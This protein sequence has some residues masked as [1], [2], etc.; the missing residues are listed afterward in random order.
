FHIKLEGGPLELLL[1]LNIS[2]HG[3]RRGAPSTPPCDAAMQGVSDCYGSEK[4][5]R[6]QDLRPGPSRASR[7][8][9]NFPTSSTWTSSAS[10]DALSED[11][12][13]IPVRCSPCTQPADEDE[14]QIR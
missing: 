5:D 11:T 10:T 1:P 8:G 14:T 4:Q 7:Y 9:N 2:L 6:L 13:L 3:H 12:W